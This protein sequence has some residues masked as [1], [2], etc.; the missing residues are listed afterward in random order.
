MT[1]RHAACSCGQLHLM[2]ERESARISMCRCLACQR[3]T[4][5]VSSNQARFRGDQVTLTGKATKWSRT[6]ES[7]SVVT[8][9]LCP[10]GVAPPLGLIAARHSAQ[11]N[12]DAGVTTAPHPEVGFG[13]TPAAASRRTTCPAACPQST[14]YVGTGS[15]GRSTGLALTPDDAGVAFVRRHYRPKVQNRYWNNHPITDFTHP[16]GSPARSG[17]RRPW[18]EEWLA[19]RC[20]ASRPHFGAS[21]A[22]SGEALGARCRECAANFPDVAPEKAAGR[23]KEARRYSV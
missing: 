5:A 10:G 1:T 18:G 21:Q 6:A 3:R 8:F 7:G 20:A 22:V 17:T 2:I 4:G 9:H 16:I 11:A 23:I 13:S 19:G 12:G 15:S 14:G